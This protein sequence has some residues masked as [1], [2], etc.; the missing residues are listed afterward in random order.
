MIK[1]LESRNANIF[2]NNEIVF[3]ITNKIEIILIK[4]SFIISNEINIK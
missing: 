4:Y 2:T 1:L 3:K